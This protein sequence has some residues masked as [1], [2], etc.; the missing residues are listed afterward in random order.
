MFSIMFLFLYQK[1]NIEISLNL[2]IYSIL[3]AA[4]LP[5]PNVASPGLATEWGGGAAT[6]ASAGEG[7]RCRGGG[8]WAPGRR[9]N[10]FF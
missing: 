2:N 1:K 10:F 4:S 7:C 5:P 9:D 8:P 6:S 3:A